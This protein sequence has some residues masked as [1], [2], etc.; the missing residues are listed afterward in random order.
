LVYVLDSYGS[1]C[2]FIDPFD[3]KLTGTRP[4]TVT[5]KLTAATSHGKEV[6]LVVYLERFD[7]NIVI[8]L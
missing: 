8:V 4:R 6:R 7:R 2:V 5:P 3:V 1:V